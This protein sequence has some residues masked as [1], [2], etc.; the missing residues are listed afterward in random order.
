MESKFIKKIGIEFEGGWY[1]EPAHL[2][3]D[4]SVED[5]RSCEFQGE[6]ASPKLSPEA[7]L[8][9][10]K[11]N[12]PDEVNSTCGLHVHVSFKN[13]RAYATLMEPEF[14][15]KFLEFWNAWGTRKAIIPETPFW[16]RL[17]GDN[18]F[19]KKLFRP[20]EQA[21][22]K[23]KASLRYCHINYCHGLHKTVEFRMLPMFKK[24][25]LA[26]DAIAD[27]LDFIENY[28]AS[29]PRKREILVE[30]VAEADLD[31]PEELFIDESVSADRFNF[32]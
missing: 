1:E 20:D 2:K 22:L 25:S 29:K 26:L 23:E 7:W 16:R 24:A 11:S 21:A 15:E 3:S 9:W 14:Y 18:R 32:R 10:A 13:N 17:R 30:E 12:Y 8:D 4:A 5:I 19:C 28:L 31:T 27:L 6:V